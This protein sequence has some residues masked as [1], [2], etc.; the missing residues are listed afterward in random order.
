MLIMLLTFAL[1]LMVDVKSHTFAHDYK[2]AGNWPFER[3]FWPYC[4]FSPRTEPFKRIIFT[5]N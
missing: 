4:C 2:I 1:M 5:E 3:V